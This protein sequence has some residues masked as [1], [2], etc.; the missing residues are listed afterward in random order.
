[1]DSF[2]P[3]MFVFSWLGWRIPFGSGLNLEAADDGR[4]RYSLLALVVLL[5][6]AVFYSGRFRT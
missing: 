1:M 6:F 5:P 2:Y 3:H 4:L